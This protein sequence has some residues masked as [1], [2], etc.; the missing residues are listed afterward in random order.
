MTYTQICDMKQLSLLAPSSRQTTLSA[1]GQKASQ[2]S[3]AI[4]I[5]LPFLNSEQF[6]PLYQRSANL[7]KVPRIT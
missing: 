7:Y 4:A 3:W 6:L 5:S 1:E 2:T